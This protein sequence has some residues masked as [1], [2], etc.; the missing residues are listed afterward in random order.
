MPKRRCGFTAGAGIRAGSTSA[1]SATA[2]S[3]RTARTLSAAS[4]ATVLAP[5]R[6]C[7]AS[8]LRRGVSIGR[9][10]VGGAHDEQPVHGSGAGALCVGHDDAHAVAACG[11]PPAVDAG[12]EADRNLAW[13]HGD[14]AGGD[15]AAMRL[16]P[17]R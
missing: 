7:T 13:L 8:G 4:N 3:A 17:A 2:R 9:S 12:G 16:G 14:A 1:I 15:T 10:V 5:V 6:R 11:E